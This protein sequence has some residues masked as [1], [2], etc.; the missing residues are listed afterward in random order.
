MAAVYRPVDNRRLAAPF[1]STA[2]HYRRCRCAR[3]FA[4][5]LGL[6]DGRPVQLL[7]RLARRAARL[8]TGSRLRRGADFGAGNHGLQNCHVLGDPTPDRPGDPSCHR[9]RARPGP[10]RGCGILALVLHRPVARHFLRVGDRTRA[11]KGRLGC[12]RRD[13]DARDRRRAGSGWAGEPQFDRTALRLRRDGH[14][15]DPAPGA[16]SPGAEPAF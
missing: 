7:Y 9:R 4:L 3:L 6:S 11:R 10:A 16:T 2:A 8:R 14:Q 15:A 12:T 13:G 1:R 5:V